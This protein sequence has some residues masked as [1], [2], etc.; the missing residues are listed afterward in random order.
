MWHC[1]YARTHILLLDSCLSVSLL[2]SNTQLYALPLTHRVREGMFFFALSACI[3]CFHSPWFIAVLS[4]VEPEKY[5]GLTREDWLVVKAFIQY[6]S[7]PTGNPA[8]RLHHTFKRWE[9]Q[10]VLVPY[11]MSIQMSIT[12]SYIICIC[13]YLWSMFLLLQGVQMS[14]Q[15]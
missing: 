11:D 9:S 14:S 8:H 10:I 5:V 1:F 12:L 3:L 2:L 15:Q 4:W 13:V 7:I 6:T